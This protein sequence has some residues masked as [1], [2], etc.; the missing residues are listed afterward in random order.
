MVMTA[1]AFNFEL[2]RDQIPRTPMVTAITIFLNA[3]K[4][5]EESIRSVFGQTFHNWELLLVDDGSTDRSTEIAKNYVNAYPK[6]IRYLEH[7]Q[8][9]N[10]GMS[11]SRNLGLRQARG[12]FISFIDADDVWVPGKLEEQIGILMAHPDAAMVYG[13]TQYWF[14]WTGKLEDSKRDYVPPLG[15]VADTVVKPP[16]LARTILLN[17]IA[18]STGCLARRNVFHEVGGYEEDFRGLFEDQVFYS[19]ISLKHPV[20][21]SSQCWCKYRKHD[22]SCC[23][24]AE[25]SGENHKER[26]KFLDWLEQYTWE[27]GVND[28]I[29]RATIRKERWKSNHPSL[30]TIE[31]GTR[32]RARILKESTKAV[33]R[34]VLPDRIYNWNRSRRRNAA[35]TP[36]VGFVSFGDLRRVTPISRVFGFDRGSPIDRYYI[37]R[38]LTRFDADIRGRVLEIGDDTYTRRFGKSLVTQSDVLHVSDENPKATIVADL[39]NADHLPSKTYDCIILTQTLQLIY[40][41]RAAL[42]T[43]Q[44]ILNPGG[45]LLATVPGISKIDHYEWRESWFWSFTSLSIDRLFRET[46]AGAAIEIETHGNVLASTAFLQGIALEELDGEELDYNDPDYPVTITVRAVK[47]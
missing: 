35:G 22:D 40:D 20:F 45:T 27:Q 31:E 5:L 10:R 11:A 37:E 12:E 23:A 15:V 33:I 39:A 34:R 14:S 44:R 30:S 9:E 2:D 7:P 47:E 21:V 6:R 41:V 4:F 3:E 26:I 43:L 24:I 42:L 46:F 1:T 19:K 38:F 16:I 25:A 32:Y 36:P 8:H 29:L 13:A 18:T 28:P 17:Q